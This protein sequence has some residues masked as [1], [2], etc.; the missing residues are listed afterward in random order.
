MKGLSISFTLGK[1]SVPNNVNLKHNMRKFV[2]KNVDVT[3]ILDNKIYKD[4]FIEDS[5]SKLFDDAVAEYN[6]SV[7]RPSMKCYTER[8]GDKHPKIW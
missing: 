6:R 7:S 1:A 4:E 8:A 3:K 5:Y 2:A